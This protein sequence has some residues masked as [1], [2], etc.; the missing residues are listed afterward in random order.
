MLVQ[1]PGPPVGCD[2]EFPATTPADGNWD[3]RCDS[4]PIV[5]E[6]TPGHYATFRDSGL[7]ERSSSTSLANASV[8]KRMSIPSGL[9][10]TL[11]EKLHDSRL[12]CGEEFVPKRIEP[13]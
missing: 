7:L 2:N 10:S 12:L 11:Y 1:S 4:S 8:S 6:M 13:F 9:T 3:A 5:G